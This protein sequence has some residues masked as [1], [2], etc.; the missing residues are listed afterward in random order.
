[1]G[2]FNELTDE[3]LE[4]GFYYWSYFY[5]DWGFHYIPN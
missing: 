5:P 2:M 1:M 3:R 4:Y